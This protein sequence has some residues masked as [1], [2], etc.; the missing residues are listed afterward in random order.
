MTKRFLFV[1]AAF[2]LMT[3]AFSAA[4][5]GQTQPPADLVRWIIE[6]AIPLETVDPA[7]DDADLTPLREVIGDARIVGLGEA[8]HG[9]SEFFTLKHRLVRFLAEEM[10]FTVFAIEANMPEAYRLNEYV[11]TG[12]GDPKALLEGMYF[13]TWNTQEVLD[14]ILWMRDYNASGRGIM[15]FT[16]FDMQIPFVAIQEV[17]A[18]VEAHDPAYLEPLDEAY[19]VV[20][21]AYESRRNRTPQKPAKFL[22]SREAWREETESVLEHLTTQ[23]AHYTAASPGE[24]AWALQNARLVV[25]D[26]RAELGGR[27]RDL[28]MADNVSWIVE[29]NPGAKVILWAHNGHIQQ[30]SDFGGAMGSVL[31]DRYGDDY[32]A[33]GFSFYEGEYNAFTPQKGLG[34]NQAKPAPPESVGGVFHATGMPLFAL[35]LRHIEPGTPGVWFSALRPMRQIGAVSFDDDRPFSSVVLAQKYDVVLFVD[36]MTASHILE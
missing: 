19:G 31:A 30:T 20:T 23:Q 1:L 5:S 4:R 11:L 34:T 10:G 25:Q 16:G 21:Q 2:T 29:Q 28:S 27:P 7:A 35:D 33:V 15:Q 9:T 12:E 32:L 24:V 26:M 22:A 3:G 8:S 18:F 36:Q 13:W 6:H 17:R 14:M